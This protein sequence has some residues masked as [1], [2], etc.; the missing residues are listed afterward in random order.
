MSL[1]I[2]VTMNETS[3]APF[4][5]AWQE[6]ARGAEQGDLDELVQAVRK[7]Q[8]EAA[9]RNL[10]P[11]LE[12]HIATIGDV[13]RLLEDRSWP[14]TEATR[15]DLEGALA[16]FVDEKDLIPDSNSKFGLLDDAIVLELAIS[17]HEHEWLAWQEFDRFRRDYPEC[18]PLDRVSWMSLRRAELDAALRHRRRTQG[19]GRQ[20]YA[21]RVEAAR[22]RVN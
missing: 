2:H 4:R 20:G 16:Y 12:P 15:R 1:A 22:F 10:P 21:S 6:A 17:A 3:L 13:T 14:L 18:G 7:H 11:F 5:A 9:Q 19:S 8:R